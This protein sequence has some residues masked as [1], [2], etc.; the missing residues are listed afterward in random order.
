MGTAPTRDSPCDPGRSDAIAIPL[1]FF[2]VAAGGVAALVAADAAAVHSGQHWAIQHDPC[3]A[4]PA[5]G[6]ATTG[7][8]LHLDIILALQIRI[9]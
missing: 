4:G 8:V 3:S 1:L 6:Q 2:P 5:R 9:D 7:S